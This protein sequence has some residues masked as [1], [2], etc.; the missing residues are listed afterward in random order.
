MN[1]EE[2]LRKLHSALLEI[3]D[4]IDRI[5]RKHGIEY[6]LDSGT[7]LGA[8]RHGGFIPWDDDAD[9]GMLRAEYEKF[10]RVAPG[11]LGPRFFLQTRESDPGFE[12]FSAKVRLNNTYFPEERNEGEGLHQ[13]I[14]VDVFPFD[15]AS[16]DPDEAVAEIKKTR[17]LYKLWAIRHRH[18][19]RE[20]LP[21]K[22]VRAAFRVLPERWF[23]SRC[24]AHFRK[25]SAKPT[26][27]VISYSYKMNSYRILYFNVAD[28]SPVTDIAFEGR[29][30][31][32]MNNVD[33]YL[34][35][36][37]DSYM[38]LPPEEQRKWHFDGEIRFE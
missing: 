18:P 1:S 35:T 22:A 21:R 31:R 19:P 6:F 10:L 24:L 23:E 12:K 4:E 32:I 14:F 9:V 3:L 20:S 36:M 7:A 34:K 37:Y 8:V 2:T 5:C 17:R 26:H 25:H 13:G 38:E 11:E 33:A 27:T 29:T 28:L 30:Y 15:F 16:D